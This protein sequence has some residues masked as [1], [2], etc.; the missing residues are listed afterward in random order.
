MAFPTNVG[1]TVAETFR[2]MITLSAIIRQQAVQMRAEAAT[3]I[4]VMRIANSVSYLAGTRAQLAALTGTPGLQQ[5]VRDQFGN[6]AIDLVTSFNAM[7]SALSNVVTWVAANFPRD[8][9]GNLQERK[10]DAQGNITNNVIQAAAL[11]QYRTLL[12]ALIATLDP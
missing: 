11:A 12:D 1:L 10:F 4:Q 7:T 5:Y 8:A 9:A 6:Q 2:S 3:D